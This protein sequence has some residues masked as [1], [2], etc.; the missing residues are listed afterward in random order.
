MIQFD[1]QVAE[2]VASS[3]VATVTMRL[4]SDLDRRVSISCAPPSFKVIYFGR[5]QKAEGQKTNLLRGGTDR[6]CEKYGNTLS[7]QSK[8]NV[9]SL[10]P[11]LLRIL[12]RRILALSSDSVRPCARAHVR[13]SVTIVTSNVYANIYRF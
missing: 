1:S 5:Q 4:E 9:L 2:E 13:T 8:F 10:N 11:M 12:P 7:D 6:Y 3:L